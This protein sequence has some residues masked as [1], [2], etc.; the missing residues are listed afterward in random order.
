VTAKPDINPPNTPRR[1]RPGPPVTVV[2]MAKRAVPGQVKTRLRPDLTD[3][4]A[5]AAHGAMLACVLER[6]GEHIAGQARRVVAVDGLNGVD[7][8]D[9][10][11]AGWAVP[12]GWDAIDQGAGDLGERLDH[13]WRAIGG[14][15]VVFLGVD[16]PDVPADALNQIAPTLTHHDAAVGPVTDGGY[17]TLAATNYCPGLLRGID[18]GSAHVYH[19][20]HEAAA[21]QGLHCAD[22]T[23]WYDVDAF[24]D[25]TALRRRI[26]HA[27]DPALRHL[28]QRLHAIVSG[29]EP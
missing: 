11:G 28:K 19:Q 29:V 16:S 25:L 6:A 10:L 3:Q 7:P 1:E 17:W 12:P 9:A 21:Q 23:R 18:W 5:A 13:V 22:L 20:T 27:E 15:A 8:G 2:V 14:G 4:Q 26:E 24:D